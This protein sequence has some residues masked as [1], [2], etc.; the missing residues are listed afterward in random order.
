M[1]NSIKF[2][3]CGRIFTSSET[4]LRRV[5]GGNNMAKQKKSKNQSN[6]DVTNNKGDTEFATEFSQSKKARKIGHKKE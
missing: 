3:I 4:E 6:A 2:P 5:K 1:K